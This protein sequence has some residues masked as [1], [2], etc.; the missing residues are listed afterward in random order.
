[1]IGAEAL[2]GAIASIS[3]VEGV[4][5]SASSL[6]QDV[7]AVAR[8]FPEKDDFDAAIA[9]T[10]RALGHIASGRVVASDLGDDYEGWH[11]YHYQHCVAQGEKADMRVMYR[12]GD[13]QVFVRGFG[14]RREP[15]DFY[16]RMA[17]ADRKSFG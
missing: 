17:A 11:A 9:N 3:A 4:F 1:M 10:A 5:M 15:A 16:R 7:V 6:A 13:G 14:H 2:L 12:V 8:A